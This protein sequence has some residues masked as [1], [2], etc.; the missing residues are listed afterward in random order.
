MYFEGP[1]KKLEFLSLEHNFLEEPKGFWEEL[2]SSCRA[3]IIRAWVT[4]SCRAYLLSESSLFVWAH[5]VLMITCG[6]TE[7]IKS[8]QLVFKKYGKKSFNQ[9]FFQRKNENFPEYQKSF[10]CEDFKVL[11]DLFPE[12]QSLRFGDKDDHHLNLFE[13]SAGPVK[14]SEIDRTLEVLMYGICEEL[15]QMFLNPSEGSKSH[16][17]RILDSFFPGYH[18]EEHWFDPWGYSMNALKSDEFYGTVHAT[19]EG[20]H[21]YVSFELNG[22]SPEEVSGFLNGIY[23]HFN[24]RS[25]D[26]IYFD[27][28]SEVPLDLARTP[29]K[30]RQSRKHRLSTGHKVSYFHWS[31]DQI[32]VFPAEKLVF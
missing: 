27:P 7:L 21:N 30:L 14:F 20:G 9:F 5:R 1:E 10:A 2:V 8:A 23:T 26:V 32:Q 12:G 17:H 29:L 25:C 31:Q 19:P 11:Q 18:K 22:I 15:S 4:P 16:I 13:Y 6:Q 3:E 28:L 24:P